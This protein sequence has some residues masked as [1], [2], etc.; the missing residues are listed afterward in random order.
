MRTLA[1]LMLVTLRPFHSFLSMN[2]GNAPGWD[3]EAG[4]S[5][6]FKKTLTETVAL[7]RA[8]KQ[9]QL[10]PALAAEWIIHAFVNSGLAHPVCPIQCPPCQNLQLF[11]KQHLQEYKDFFR[12]LR[13][14][15]RK[16]LRFLSSGVVLV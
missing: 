14:Y 2:V 16:M 9:A 10:F 11:M 3:S 6:W 12:S 4:Y 1:I 7:G 13:E 8:H 15:R 5:G